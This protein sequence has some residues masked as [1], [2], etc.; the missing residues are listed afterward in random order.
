M[1]QPFDPWQPQQSRPADPEWGQGSQD[2]PEGQYQPPQGYRPQHRAQ[3]GYGQQ[4]PPQESPWQR[5]PSPPG[6]HRRHGLGQP[7]QAPGTSRTINGR[8]TRRPASGRA[9]PGKTMAYTS[10]RRS[11]SHRGDPAP[12]CT[13]ASPHWS[14]S[15]G[16]GARHMP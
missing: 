15:P 5:A 8:I 3:Q 6:A 10:R 13:Q 12:D 11:S 4:Y 2:W 1:T 7:E 9:S 14:S 16:E